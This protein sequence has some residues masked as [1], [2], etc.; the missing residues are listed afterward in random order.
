MPAPGG[1]GRAPWPRLLVAEGRSDDLGPGL[2]WP[3]CRPR[4]IGCWR[5]DMS[6]HGLVIA[7]SLFLV[8]LAFAR[9]PS[10][11]SAPLSGQRGRGVEVQSSSPVVFEGLVFDSDGAPAEGAVVV[12]SAGGRAVV[13][14]HG[15]YR[16]ESTAPID[17]R[18]VQITAIASG[19]GG[20]AA[21]TRVDL[22]TSSGFARVDPLM[23]ALGTCQPSWLPDFRGLPGTN[24]WV[25]AF[26]VFDDGG[27]SALYVGGNFTSAGRV[28]ANR[29]A[30]WDGERWS[31][32][33]SGMSVGSSSLG[34]YALAV[35]DDGSG[36]ALYAGGDF[37]RAG[38]LA[39]NNVAKWD[40]TSWAAL[41]S[42]L[43][44]GVSALAVF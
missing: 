21:T 5:A 13:D 35:F 32:L 33:G 8:S 34:V 17:A 7:R 4:E 10:A 26:E 36:S 39:A 40:G 29:I 2:D 28:M 15:R 9:S 1:R 30:K 22:S 23:L 43:N 19:G 24:G 11:Q 25:G 38:G 42:G 3:W 14:R 20:G 27:G 37:T 12:S 41:G 18:S 44:N 31:A 16:L 6:M